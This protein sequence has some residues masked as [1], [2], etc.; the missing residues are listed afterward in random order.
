MKIGLVG[1]S[2]QQR[3]LPFDAQR[4]IN[5]YPIV[6][7][8]GKETAS[9]LGTPGLSLF[10]S[11]GAGPARGCFKSGNGNVY[12]VI[13]FGLYQVTSAQNTI[14]LG[15]LETGTGW[16]S[17]CE[18]T[19]HLAISDESKIYY[20]TYATS[21][22]GTVTDADLPAS[23]GYLTNID[24]YFVVVN[25]GTGKFHISDL[26]DVTSWQALDY[27]TAESS[28][29][30]LLAPV[31]AV[32]QLWLLGEKTTEVWSNTGASAFP[33]ARISGAV[34]KVGILAKYSAREVDNTVFWIGRDELGAGIVYRANG[35]T[36]LRISTSTIEQKI[37]EATDAENIVAWAYQEDGHLFYML[38][39]GGLETSLV[40]DVTTQQWHERA[41]RSELGTLGQHLG[42]CHVYAF[43]KH[44]I[45]SYLTGAIYEMS[46]NLYTDNGAEIVRERIYTHISDEGRRIRFNSL[47]IGMETGVGSV[48]GSDPQLALYTSRDGART[49]SEPIT[50]SLGKVGEYKKKV[51]F[52]RL[53][54]ADQL[55]FKL[56]VTD[57]VKVAIT[58]SYLQ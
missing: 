25:A 45:G 29:D 49:W 39:G 2:Y 58:G 53:G 35:F 47:E 42:T 27:A 19:T 4:T 6:D 50:G 5:L 51:K 54:V 13:G 55:T 38:T 11:V 21:A 37:S 46:L 16:V 32:G 44:L 9:L 33:F 3:S 23:I 41:Y 43:G 26:N 12:F 22:F 15:A 36:P 34:M 14:Y 17:M 48:D 57:S 31:A 56:R 30:Y 24:G 8:S 40:Y 18:S 20:L 10:A 1:P 52:R 7:Q 28:P